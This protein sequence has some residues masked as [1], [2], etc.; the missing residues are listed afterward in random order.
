MQLVQSEFLNYVEECVNS[1]WPARSI[2]EAAF[3]NAA[4]IDPSQQIIKLGQTCPWQAHIFPIEEARE[5]KGV[6][7]YVIFQD[8]KGAWRVQAVPTEEGSF[9]NRKPLP[10]AWCGLKD[11]ELSEKS[12]IEGCVFVHAGGFIGGHAT[13]DGALAMAKQAITM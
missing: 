13:E 10:V 8:L 3:D 4:A 9:A 11:G 7:K 1:W 12:G 5:A 2:V 6:V